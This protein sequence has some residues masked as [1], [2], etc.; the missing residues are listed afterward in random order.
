MKRIIRLRGFS[1]LKLSAIALIIILLISYI[2]LRKLVFLDKNALM[3]GR[4]ITLVAKEI[5]D[6]LINNQG[7]KRFSCTT[8]DDVNISGLIIEKNNPQ[9]TIILC[10]GY[11]CCK[12]LSAGYTKIF[13]NFNSVL[14]DFRGHGENKKSIT[15]VGCHEH[16]DVAAVV[17]W[18]KKN[19]PKLLKIPLIILGV[20]M[21]GAAAL[22]AAEY[23]K[24]LCDALIID[25]SFASLKRVFYNS[26][27]HRS[28]LPTFPFLTIMEKMFNYLGAC[29][30][31]KMNPIESVKKIKQPLLLI[32]SCIDNIVPVNESLLMYAQAELTRAKLWIAPTCKHGWLHKK[33]PDLYKKKVLKFIKKRITNKLD[34]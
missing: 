25:S 8:S 31:S 7:A 1:F 17:Q 11:R 4:R 15:T 5:R 21:G 29:N 27:V 9:A 33:Y 24:N 32:H 26:F 23:D 3:E 28:G 6:D 16:K 22:K 10:H 12:E 19:K 30:A 34:L 14:F 2:S 20:S 18:I 13:D